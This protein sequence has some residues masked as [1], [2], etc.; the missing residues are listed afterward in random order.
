MKNSRPALDEMVRDPAQHFE[1]PAAVLQEHKLSKE[2]KRSILESWKVDE[3]ELS[4]ATA[5]N[6]GKQ[7]DN[8]LPEVIAALQKLAN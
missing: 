7:D 6:M 2:Q 1:S 4:T 3:E 5:E 8:R